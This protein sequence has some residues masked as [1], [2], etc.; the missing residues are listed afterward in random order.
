MFKNCFLQKTLF[1]EIFFFRNHFKH[2]FGYRK[3]YI[4]RKYLNYVYEAYCL[5]LF[6]VLKFGVGVGK[7]RI[8]RKCFKAVLA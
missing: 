3:H 5:I 2:N 7:A 8:F 1:S 4:F 6:P